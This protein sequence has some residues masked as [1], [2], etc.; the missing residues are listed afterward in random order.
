MSPPLASAT[1]VSRPSTSTWPQALDRTDARPQEAS[2]STQGQNPSPRAGTQGQN[3]A[4]GQNPGLHWCS[5]ELGGLCAVD[6]G[7]RGGCACR[8][9]RGHGVKVACADL[10]QAE[11]FSMQN[12]GC[13]V[14]CNQMT[15]NTAS[16]W[17][18]PT[19]STG[20]GSGSGFRVQGLGLRAVQDD[21]QGLAE[22]VLGQPRSSQP[23]QGKSCRLELCVI[24]CLLSSNEFLTTP[25]GCR[26][27]SP[28]SC[29]QRPA[30]ALGRW[31]SPQ[32]SLDSAP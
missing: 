24:D 23:A 26:P 30:A 27:G 32:T 9:D 28:P 14:I 10:Q 15:V 1:V 11:R 21:D 7:Q 4:Q 29:T 20:R 17:P 12:L 8:D 5:V 18:V 31:C 6:Q 25:P 3:P 2:T 13:R 16:K 22:P 19:C